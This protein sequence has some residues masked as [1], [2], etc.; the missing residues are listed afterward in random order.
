VF[1]PPASAA[2]AVLVVATAR[3]GRDAIEQR[4]ARIA[5]E[6]R[7]AGYVSPNVLSALLAGEI[8]AARPLKYEEL[9]FMFADIRGFVT[10][11]E[12][13]PPETVVELLNR[14]YEV[15]TEAIHAFEGTIDNFRGDGIKAIFGAPRAVSDAPRR[16][17]LAGREMLKRVQALNLK[18][19]LEGFAPLQIGMGLASGNAVVGNLGSST[20]HDYTAIG[21]SVNVAARLQSLCKT[22]GMVLIATE[23]VARSCSGELPL[24]DLGLLELSGHSPVHAFG[25]PK[26]PP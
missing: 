3:T 2:A 14:Y 5:I 11:N 23:S 8:D 17:A 7:F 9:G 6:R 13:L 22:L 10:L 24:R 25:I 1:V 4:R 21:D 20:R 19:T 26:D 16:C 15:V 18:L 12:A